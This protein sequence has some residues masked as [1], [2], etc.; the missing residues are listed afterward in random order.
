VGKLAYDAPICGALW[1]LVLIGTLLGR[2]WL[3]N[4]LSWAPLR[5]LGLISFSAYLWHWKFLSD[6]DDL[7]V[8]PILRLAV[9][10]AIVIVVSSVSYF[11]IERPLQ[12]VRLGR[13]DAGV[14]GP[15]REKAP[16]GCQSPRSEPLA[17]PGD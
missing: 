9:F 4:G 1:S 8:P 7:P 14:N 12:R 10:L 2:G 15:L 16:R 6:V 3:A 11:L 5:Y 13:G 17:P